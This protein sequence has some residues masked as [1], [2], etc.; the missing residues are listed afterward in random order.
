MIV[1]LFNV[2]ETFWTF[3]HQTKVDL[4]LPDLNLLL[5]VS[6]PFL[7][8]PLFHQVLELPSSSLLKYR[9]FVLSNQK[10]VFSNQQLIYQIVV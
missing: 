7:V 8:F 2:C 6:N 9:Q 10:F 4:F 3:Y 1:M 5:F